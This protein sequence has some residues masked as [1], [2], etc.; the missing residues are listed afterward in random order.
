MAQL[1]KDPSAEVR[2]EVVR[3]LAKLQGA[4]MDEAITLALADKEKSVRVTGLDLLNT[5]Q[6]PNE[7]KVVLL[8]N[9]IATRTPEERQAAITTLGSLP[10]T[11]TEKV[12]TGLVEQMEKGTL[13]R[14][15]WLELSD[16]LD[17]SGAKALKD[18]YVKVNA[19]AG[20]DSLKA[21]FAGALVGGDP[22]KGAAIF[23]GDGSAQCVRC[24]AINDYGGHVGPNLGGVASRLKPEQLLE[25]VIE[26]SAR[27]APGFGQV[28]L[29]MK[30]GQKIVGILQEEKPDTYRVKVGD[31]SDTLI[32]R[33]D[34]ANRTNSPSSMP[35]MYLLLNK[36]EIRD[37]VSYL[38]TL[39]SK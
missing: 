25:A 7:R 34:V 11:G 20:P 4:P 5:L 9:V 3:S 32:K 13:P 14:E 12:L 26:P 18:R 35:P 1:K 37:V 8:G 24:H 6:L 31:K 33:A 15:V 38:G 2:T 28:T 27:I 17:S 21:M 29:D 36:K 30:G 22:K 39:K 16:A 10:L 19:K 23:W